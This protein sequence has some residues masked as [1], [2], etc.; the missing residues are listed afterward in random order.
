MN[1]V[2]KILA[3]DAAKAAPAEAR[4]LIEAAGGSVGDIGSSGDGTVERRTPA[5]AGEGGD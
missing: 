2:E 3:S 5:A 4:R 1:W